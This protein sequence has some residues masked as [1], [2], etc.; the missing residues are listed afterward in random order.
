MN[1]IKYLICIVVISFHFQGFTQIN[2]EYGVKFGV[3]LADLRTDENSLSPR[4]TFHFGFEAEHAFDEKF[5]LQTELLYSRQGEVRRG[6][7]LQNTKFNNI[8]ALDYINI[9]VMVNYYVVDGFYVTM[10]P[11]IGFLVRAQLEETIGVNSDQKDVQENYRNAD[12][13]AVFGAG[14]KTDWGFSVGFR[15]N[16]GFTNV[17]KNPYVYTGTEKNSVLQLSMSYRFK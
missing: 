11:Q 12:F 13:S 3:N 10:G 16:L 8:L 5:S 1:K 2:L 17:L 7:T 4:A 6:R 14:Y 15:Y 9:P